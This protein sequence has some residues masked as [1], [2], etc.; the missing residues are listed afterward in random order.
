MQAVVTLEARYIFVDIVGYTL[1]RSIEAQVDLIK[2]LN[3]IIIQAFEREGV[4]RERLMFFPVGDGVCSAI[5]G[6]APDRAADDYDA[7]V[8]VAL[9][10][11]EL[12]HEYNARTEDAMR[13]FS[14]RVGLNDNIDNAV[15]DINGNDNLA[16]SG[17]NGAQRVM[18]AAEASQL[19]VSRAVYDRL[20]DREFYMNAFREVSSYTKHG[21]RLTVYQ[22]ILNDRP[23]LDVSLPRSLQAAA[24]PRLPRLLGYYMRA[25]LQHQEELLGMPEL[26]GNSL[27]EDAARIMYYMMALDEEAQERKG[28][29]DPPTLM[30]SP[31]GDVTFR[32]RL[33][34]YHSQ[35]V[36]I[37][38]LL[39]RKIEALTTFTNCFDGP[40]FVYVNECGREKLRMDHPDLAP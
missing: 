23:G 19:F 12:L 32:E 40:R 9:R 38:H 4:P 5:L 35:D 33:A 31:R 15:T 26:P 30:L 28:P 2:A 1:K 6:N 10:M 36:W 8:R 34:Y 7:H 21:E 11:L 14:I 18:S 37:I 13:R 29:Y 25:A 16:G 17:I 20:R 27:W 24:E 3:E 39:A 22:V